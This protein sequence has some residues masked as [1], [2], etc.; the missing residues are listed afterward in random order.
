SLDELQFLQGLG[1]VGDI[2]NRFFNILGQQV[3]V[4]TID[5]RVIGITWQ[6]INRIDTVLGIAT[7]REKIAA[8]LGAIRT[9]LVD[10]LI[11]DDVSAENVLHLDEEIPL[12]EKVLK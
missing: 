5:P 10:I 12:M 3:L 9:G 7:G 2:Y 11:T 8:I 1:V 4:P 6:D